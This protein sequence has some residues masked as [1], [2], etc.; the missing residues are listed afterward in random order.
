MFVDDRL[1]VEGTV[2]G[3]CVESA[4]VGEA[5]SVLRGATG[6]HFVTYGVSDEAAAEVG[7]MCGG[8]VEVFVH[9]LMHVDLPALESANEA[10][11]V[12]RPVAIATSLAGS[13]AGSKMAVID[14]DTV[15][16]LGCPA[17]G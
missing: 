8:T 9:E 11:G 1:K 2:T 12:E 7:L 4:L 10:Q 16:G 17:P 3:G 15:G 5:E 6:P 14:G 13:R